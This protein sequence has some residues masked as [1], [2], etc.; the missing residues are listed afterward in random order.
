M[1]TSNMLSLK[2]VV[3]VCLGLIFVTKALP[4]PKDIHI[5]VHGLGKMME[6]EPDSGNA[7]ESWSRDILTQE[8]VCLNTRSIEVLIASKEATVMVLIA[9]SG[10]GILM[11]SVL[12]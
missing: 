3:I 4:R 12:K 6:T 9:S 11:I 7:F 5:H 8:V 10:A 1:G 2:H